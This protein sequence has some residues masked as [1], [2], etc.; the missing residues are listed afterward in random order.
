MHRRNSVPA[1]VVTVVPSGFILSLRAVS[2]V[3]AVSPA[4]VHSRHNHAYHCPV[5]PRRKVPQAEPHPTSCVSGVRYR[6]VAGAKRE[7]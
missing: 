6:R 4:A 1:F 5:L 3:T 2:Y 7:R